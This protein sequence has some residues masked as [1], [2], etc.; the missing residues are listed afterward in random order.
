[1]SLVLPLL[2]RKSFHSDCKFVSHQNKMKVCLLPALEDNYMYLLIDE[3]TKEA[4]IVD[5]VEPKKVMDAV[6]EENCKLTTVLTTHHH[7][8]HAGGNADL[9]KLCP[10]L[11]VVGGDERVGALTRKVGDGDQLSVGQL[12]IKCLFTPC[13]TKGHI[14]YFVT[15]NTEPNTDPLVF[16]GFRVNTFYNSK[17]I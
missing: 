8:D 5:P 11:I 9:V 12:N 6:K 3:N 2:R 13:H 1:M 10:E 14:C 15:S 16:T 7:W 17:F 4:A